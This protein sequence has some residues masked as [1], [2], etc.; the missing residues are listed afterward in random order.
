MDKDYFHGEAIDWDEKLERCYWRR[1]GFV[2]FAAIVLAMIFAPLMVCASVEPDAKV[3]YV[4]VL[5]AT[6]DG[7]AV[8]VQHCMTPEAFEASQK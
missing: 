4:K 6:G 1:I 8:V 3:C 7:T 2:I 5:G